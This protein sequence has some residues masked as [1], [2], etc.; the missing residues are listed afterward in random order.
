MRPIIDLNNTWH[1][2]ETIVHLS[3]FEIFSA[4]FFQI[5]ILLFV[6]FSLINSNYLASILFL[7]PTYFLIKKIIQFFNER[8]K[9]QLIINSFGIKVKDEP[10]ISWDHI[11]NE[12][13]IRIGKKNN[14]RHDFV[15]Y[16]ASQHKVIQIRTDVLNFGHFE[17]IKSAKIHRERF[18]RKNNPSES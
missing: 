17:L 2:E 16:D 10:I 3:R 11:E 5:L 7:I 1:S 14:S 4:C 15:F 12:R 9:I 18:N 6:Y 8:N 13:V